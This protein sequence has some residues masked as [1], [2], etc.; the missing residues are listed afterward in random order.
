MELSTVKLARQIGHTHRQA[1]QTLAHW[2][3]GLGAK[4][5]HVG[6]VLARFGQGAQTLIVVEVGCGVNV[7]VH[8][9][10]HVLMHQL[11]MQ[12]MIVML[13][14]ML[15][16]VQPVITRIPFAA[17]GNSADLAFGD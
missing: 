1:L 12:L 9:V 6:K 10:H 14:V 8:L 17:G 3:A 7:R 5:T 16:M 4:V 13:K 11:V 2:L 15:K